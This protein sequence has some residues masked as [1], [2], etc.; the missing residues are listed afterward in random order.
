[1]AGEYNSKI[2][3][4]EG[5]IPRKFIEFLIVEI[6]IK[7]VE[8]RNLLL[9][10]TIKPFNGHEHKSWEIFWGLD[11]DDEYTDLPPELEEQFFSM[12]E[13]YLRQHNY[14]MVKEPIDYEEDLYDFLNEA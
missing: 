11:I 6:A 9:A 8:E 3:V 7:W 5:Y 12:I 1:M 14:K 13:D 4:D 10:T 2:Y